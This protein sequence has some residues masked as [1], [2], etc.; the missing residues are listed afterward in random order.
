MKKNTEITDN[1]E[2]IGDIQENRVGIDVENLGFITSLLTSNL[3]SNPVESFL[4][5]SVSN[6]YDSHVEAG[7]DENILLLIQ[8][9]E[10]QKTYTIFVRDYGTGLSP[11]RFDKI[12]RNIGSSTKRESNDYIGFFGIGRFAGLSCADEVNITSYYNN[13]K[14]DYVIYKRDDGINIDKINEEPTDC[15]NGLE[16]SVTVNCSRSDLLLAMDKLCLFDKLVIHYS[17]SGD[18]YYGRSLKDYEAKFNNRKIVN[19]KNFSVSNMFPAGINYFRVGNV[20]YSTTP[21]IDHN[22]ITGHGIIINLEIGSVDITPN[23][24]ALQFTERTV[25]YINKCIDATNDEIKS[26]ITDIPDNNMTLGDYFHAFCFEHY[27]ARIYDDTSLYVKKANVNG[28]IDVSNIKINNVIPPIEF[29][30]FLGKIKYCYINKD[31]IYYHK[32]AATKHSL[33]PI[34]LMDIIDDN[35][36]FVEKSDKTTRSATLD[37]FFENH[38]GN[39]II[40]KHDTINNIKEEIKKYFNSSNYYVSFNG[41]VN[42]CIRY[43]F[44]SIG[45]LEL[46]NSDVPKDYIGKTVKSKTKKSTK[47]SFSEIPIRIYYDSQYRKSYM[48]NVMDRSFV[49]Y[50]EHLYDDRKIRELSGLLNRIYG[51]DVKVISLSKDNVPLLNNKKKFVHMSNFTEKR[52][53][54]FCKIATSQI[55]YNNFRSY[56]DICDSYTSWPMWNEFQ[57]K[58]KRITDLLNHNYGLSRDYVEKIVKTYT[59]NNWLDDYAIKYFALNDNEKSILKKWTTALSYKSGIIT[60]IICGKYGIINKIGL[61]PSK[62]ISMNFINTL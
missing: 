53:K 37:Y 9:N 14:Y 43:L 8:N 13:T 22:I 52:N 31:F 41:D 27:T 30:K 47:L 15:R 10:D 59:E 25:N 26:L 55:I 19:L 46:K 39:Y 54:L 42:S 17:P 56:Y 11:E 12:Y 24:E 49:V 29:D 32:S 33:K 58:Y 36:E 21:S 57:R 61:R 38:D 2:Y 5:E 40:L 35:Y 16:V 1:V 23:R 28:G 48:S 18:D 34:R 60:N 45:V 51:N 6:A 20:L 4:R 44:D 7:T 50:S 3:Y 62:Y